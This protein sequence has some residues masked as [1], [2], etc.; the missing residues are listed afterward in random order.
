MTKQTDNPIPVHVPGDVPKAMSAEY[1]KNFTTV[2]AGRGRMMLF[3]GDQKIEHLNDDFTGPDASSE[4]GD[5]E[6]L[7]KIASEAKITAFASQLGTIARYGKDYPDVPYVIKL[8]S[9]TNLVKTAQQDP[10]SLAM[11]DIEQVMRFKESSSLNVVGIGY[12]LY[13]GSEYEYLMIAEVTKLIFE[14]H[15]HGLITIVWMYPRGKAVT[16]ERDPH[17]IAGATGVACCIGT[18]FVKVNF[19]KI[20]ETNDPAKRAE[21]FKEAIHAAGTTH[22]ICSGGEK[23]AVDAFLQQLWDQIHISGARG[24]AT[25]RNIHERTLEEAK[26]FCAAIYAITIEDKSVE[27]AM[28]IYNAKA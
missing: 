5:P 16:N 26:R 17:L 1:V 20:A 14:A 10:V 23:M 27:E 12:T 19:P 18:D 21:L 22:V 9:K 4:S 2:T 28:A 15:Q 8:N 13:L 25:G 3:A 11:H 24:N 7:F 6:H